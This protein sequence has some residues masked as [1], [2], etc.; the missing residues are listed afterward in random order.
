MTHAHGGNYM[1][2]SELINR[3]ILNDVKKRVIGAQADSVP[4]DEDII[5]EINRAFGN[6]TDLGV[7]PSSGFII[8]SDAEVWGDFITDFPR[9]ER[10]KN[11]ICDK[12][13][14]H[15]DPPSSSIH[16]EALKE[17]IAELE[18]RLNVIVDPGESG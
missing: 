13:R 18:W 10:V 7:G 1:A 12:V 2:V 8:E 17:A 15:F 6:L 5:M 4:F 16:M 11:Y 14:L 3:S 9:L